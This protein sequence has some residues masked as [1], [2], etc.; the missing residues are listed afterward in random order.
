MSRAWL[1][2][3]SNLGDRD[4]YLRQAR[5]ALEASGIRIRRASSIDE[6]DPVGVTDQP[7]FLNQVLEVETQLEPRPLLDGLK[8][9]ERRL[10]RTPGPRWG[11]REID[12]DIL[13]YD[14]RQIDEPGL[15]IPHSE[16]ERR[17]FLKKLL[18]QAGSAG[19]VP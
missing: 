3:G 17:P 19:V 7:R 6:T 12:I 2:L 5:T 18:D 9:I 1:A 14:D 11:P 13:T 10:G 4:G 8:A 16:L 15:K